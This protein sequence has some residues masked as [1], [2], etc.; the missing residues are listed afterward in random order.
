MNL[1]DLTS[2]ALHINNLLICRWTCTLSA[3][4][5]QSQISLGVEPEHLIC[6]ADMQTATIFATL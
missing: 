6:V 3:N 5:Y 2:G 4:L 1:L